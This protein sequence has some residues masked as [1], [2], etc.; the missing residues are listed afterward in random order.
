M[1]ETPRNARPKPIRDR[2]TASHS[3]RFT[4]NRVKVPKPRIY[5]ESQVL[6]AIC[7][8][9]SDLHLFIAVKT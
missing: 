4:M 2:I 3:A 6:A 1:T 9:V 7:I 8:Q 5:T